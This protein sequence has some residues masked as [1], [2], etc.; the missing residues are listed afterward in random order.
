MQ[1]ESC[2]TSCIGLDDPRLTGCF[3]EISPGF[4]PGQGLAI[5][6]RWKVATPLG[7]QTLYGVDLFVARKPGEGGQCAAGEAGGIADE[8]LAEGM[9]GAGKLGGRLRGWIGG[10]AMDRPTRQAGLARQGYGPGKT[11]L[12]NQVAQNFPRAVASSSMGHDGRIGGIW[13][14]G[15]I[16]V[17]LA[18]VVYGR[19]GLP[20]KFGI[21]DLLRFL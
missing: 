9:L 18:A 12:S 15:Q 3:P 8:L 7:E 13:R 11:A 10:G 17:P 6:R 2:R 14:N 16:D 5:P 19:V 20:V 1:C 4:L 21:N